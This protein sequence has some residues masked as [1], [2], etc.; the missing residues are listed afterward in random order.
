MDLQKIKIEAYTGYGNKKRIVCRGR[1]LVDNDAFESDEDTILK[2]IVRT[3]R[4]PESELVT[5]QVFQ[6]K[7]GKLTKE[8]KTNSEGFYYLKQK[9]ENFEPK[10]RFENIKISILKE[11]KKDTWLKE[12]IK[13]T[14][15]ILFPDE[16]AEFGIVSD[17]DDTILKTDV[18]SPFK[19]KIFYN[20][21]F[22]KASKRMAIWDANTWYNKLKKGTKNADNPFFYV[23]NSPWNLFTY[24]NEFLRIN[25]FP[26]GPIF[27]RDFGRNKKDKLQSYR[28]H[29]TDEIESIIKMYPKLPLILIGDGGERDAHIYL[30]LKEKYPTNVKA[31]FIRRLGDKKH[32]AI[33]EELAKGH[34]DYFFFIKTAKKGIKISKK[35]G[36]IAV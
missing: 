12:R 14:G 28:N 9:I 25:D 19:W 10:K 2:D 22:V 26:E 13:S 24:L 33:I 32:Q 5:K 7:F 1:I 4:R 17:I 21:L 20:T 29:K 30:A 36:L 11:H 15:K 35:L 6:V 18:M 16:N 23:S 3:Y 27:L 34:E 31:I 8:F